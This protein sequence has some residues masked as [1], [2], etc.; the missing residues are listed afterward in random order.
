M[1]PYNH[2]TYPFPVDMDQMIFF[3][4]NFHDEVRNCFM[5]DSLIMRRYFDFVL[6]WLS[7]CYFEKSRCTIYLSKNKI[8][9]NIFAAM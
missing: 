6:N 5:E 3:V 2:P 1:S 9:A 8:M 7:H 4:A